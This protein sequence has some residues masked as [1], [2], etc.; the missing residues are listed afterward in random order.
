V[1]YLGSGSVW[2]DARFAETDRFLCNFSE[3]RMDGDT[4]VQTIFFVWS[5]DLLH[6][7]KFAESDAFR[8]DERFYQ[9]IEPGAHEPWQ[10]PRW[11]CISAVPRKEGG[12]YGYWTATPKDFLGFG[13]G[14]S[15]DGLHWQALEP[16]HIEWGEAPRMY[17]IEVGGVQEIE[18]RYHAMLADYASVNCG[19]FNFVADAPSGPFRPSAKNFALLRN[20]S[21]MHA[22][23][24]R[25]LDSP[26]GVLVN[27]HSLGEG[28]FMDDHFA[29]YYAPLKRARLI[30]GSLYL[31]WWEGNDRLKDRQVELDP[32]VETIWFEADQGILLEGE[33]ALPGKLMIHREGGAG[34]G[35]LVNEKGIT[36]IGPIAS[37]WSRFQCEESVDRELTFG[38]TPHFHLLLY[39]TMLEFYL[40]DIFIQCYTLEKAA[41]GLISCQNLDNMKLWQW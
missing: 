15:E 2:K 28:Q 19:I 36:E 4:N 13:F 40:E 29:V 37:D 32:S 10:D 22:Y 18:G 24:T 35:I 8:I 7:Y 39:R 3:W 26:N 33:I 31:A 6:W 5:D 27:H 23:F 14:V 12:Y 34:I 25:F 16:P 9:R 38:V 20:Q 11:D 41:S 30:D 17:F 1:R 21:K